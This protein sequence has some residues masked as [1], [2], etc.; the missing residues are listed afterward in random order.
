VS[1]GTVTTFSGFASATG[2]VQAGQKV[3]VRGLLFKSTPSGV[4]LMA[5][6]VLLRP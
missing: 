1:T 4:Q 2:P 5:G 3:S 6:N